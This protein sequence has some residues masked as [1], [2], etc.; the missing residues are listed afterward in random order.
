V[1]GEGGA[2][3]HTSLW[4]LL[5]N[6]WALWQYLHTMGGAVVSGAFVM[7]GVGAFYLLSR[8]QEDYG[9]LFL[10]VGVLV[11][12]GASFFQLWPSGDAQGQLVTQYQ[13]VALAAMEGLFHTERGAAIVILGQPNTEQQRLDNPLY[14]PRALSFLTHRRWEAEVKG[15]SA[16]PR[17]QWPDNIPLLYFCYHIMVGLGTVFVAVMAGAAFLLWLR[18][19]FTARWMLWLVML[20]SPFPFIANT[21]GWMTAELG[22]QPWVIYGLMR[23][24][25]GF[26]PTVSAGNGLFTLMGFLG[27]YTLL[28]IVFLFL[29]W[30]EVTHGPAF[31]ADTVPSTRTSPETTQY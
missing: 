20:S 28:S 13:P 8:R 23:T 7:A 27:M 10:K 9:R 16:F 4:A 5:G 29:I 6:E 31:L 19:L 18:R 22:R 25:E 14:V 17:D 1:L 2:A 3:H 15:L 21:A 24:A 26:S 11:A 30:H 12:A